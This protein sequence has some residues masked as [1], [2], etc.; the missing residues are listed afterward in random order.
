VNRSALTL[1]PVAAL[2]GVGWLYL[3][4]YSQPPVNPA[5]QLTP[6]QIP[7]PP[8]AVTVRFS[9][10][11][12]LLFS[13]GETAWMID[14][15]FTRP[16][17]L[18]T[19]FGKVEPDL[20]AISYGLEANAVTELAA[21]VPVHSHYD[22]AM[23]APEVAR[24][25]G[26]M[27][28]GSEA[29]ANIARGWGLPEQQIRVV[30]NRER[31]RLGDFELTFLESRHLPYP[32]PELVER[33]L[34]QSEI[35]EPLVPPASIYDYKLGKAYV[36]HIAHPAGSALVVGSAGFVP[37]LLQDY[38]VDQL[39]LGIGALGSQTANY[40]E[41]YWR[42]TVAATSPEQL[43]LIHWDSLTSPIDGPLV[44]EV[45]AATLF[46]GGVGETLGFLEQK[47]QTTPGLRLATLPRF[48]PV[49]LMPPR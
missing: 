19:L 30:G 22:H 34:T 20:R 48:E 4:G 37:E 2:L 9:G 24:R 3:F 39:F 35:P 21:V 27:V 41:D 13:D 31:V 46:A 25:T 23:D 44:G 38:D 29:T 36:L 14:G 26:A 47:A 1:L 10:T 32:D 5:W 18:Q 7:P 28:I 45:R 33:L 8:G 42:H 17:P 15:W 16:G 40:R 11:T 12:T 6:T 49:L 43:I